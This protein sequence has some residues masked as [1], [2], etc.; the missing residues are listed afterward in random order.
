MH[1]SLASRDIAQRSLLVPEILTSAVGVQT[2]EARP[3]V[4]RELQA[5]GLPKQTRHLEVSLP[6]GITYQAGDHLGIC[7]END[8]EQVARLARR[9]GA[10][11]D[12]LFRVPGTIDVSA[13]PKGVV[14]QVRNVLPN[15][16]DITGKPGVPLVD[17]LLKKAGDPAERSMLAQIRDILETPGAAIRRCARRW[18]RAVSMWS[19]CWMISRPAR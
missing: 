19:G 13:V 16:A 17:L 18:T 3:L 8:R 10:A 5:D 14:L 1:R 4:C 15:L 9:L 12:G 7:P 6:P 11:L 2:A